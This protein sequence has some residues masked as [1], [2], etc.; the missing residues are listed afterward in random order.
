MTIY[1]QK[2]QIKLFPYQID[3]SVKSLC[4]GVFRPYHNNMCCIFEVGVLCVEDA[5]FPREYNSGF[6]RMPDLKLCTSNWIEVEYTHLRDMVLHEC[7]EHINTKYYIFRA[8]L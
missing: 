8:T 1:C 2:I 3:Y 7:S 6:E 4:E 5:T